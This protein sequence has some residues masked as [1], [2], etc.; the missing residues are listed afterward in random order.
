MENTDLLDNIE[1]RQ[2][3]MWTIRFLIAGGSIIVVTFLIS[4]FWTELGLDRD[5]TIILPAPLMISFGLNISGFITGIQERKINKK[6]ALIGIVGNLLCLLF[7]IFV[8]AYSIL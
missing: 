1:P 7:F 5:A 8:V 6:R 4:T 3:K 2:H